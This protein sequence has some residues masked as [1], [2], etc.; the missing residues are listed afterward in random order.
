MKD[1]QRRS[2]RGNNVGRFG[3]FW[4]IA[5]RIGPANV[6]PVDIQAA[7]RVFGCQRSEAQKKCVSLYIWGGWAGFCSEMAE[8]AAVKKMCRILG[9]KRL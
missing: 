4:G 2:G 1:E 6:V 9:G 3:A 8:K 5:R 7:R